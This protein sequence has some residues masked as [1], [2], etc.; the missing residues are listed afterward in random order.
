MRNHS[1]F[2][3]VDQVWKSCW[4]KDLHNLNDIIPVIET[5][6][7]MKNSKPNLKP[8]LLMQLQSLVQY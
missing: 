2:G 3:T 7:D 5:S 8:H 4:E 1:Q 6:T